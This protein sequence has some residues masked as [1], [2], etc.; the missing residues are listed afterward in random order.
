MGNDIEVFERENDEIDNIFWNSHG[1]KDESAYG[2][3]RRG[4]D[5][6]INNISNPIRSSY[7]PDDLILDGFDTR[8]FKLISHRGNTLRCCCWVNHNKLLLSNRNPYCI[9][10]LHTNT[11]N[12]SDAT[13]I[14]SVC[15]RIGA[16]LVSFDFEGFTYTD[17]ISFFYDL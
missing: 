5:T 6:F 17:R 1:P 12:L 8:E 7:K 11:R 4:F 14:V 10:Y 15:R 3:F 13:E 2:F 9:L 16:D